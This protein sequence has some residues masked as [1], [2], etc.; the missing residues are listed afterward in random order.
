LT[1]DEYWRAL[2]VWGDQSM[3]REGYD[4]TIYC[5]EIWPILAKSAFYKEGHYQMA[6]D[7]KKDLKS[8]EK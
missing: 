6:L 5:N 8:Y 1:E 3:R 7:N 2:K 4:E